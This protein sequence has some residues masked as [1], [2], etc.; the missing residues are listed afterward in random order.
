MSEPLTRE[1]IEGFDTR[2]FE[3]APCYLCGY[4]G[5]GYYQPETHPCAVRY[6]A[7]MEGKPCDVK[8]DR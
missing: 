7:Q 8:T 6:H 1:Q 2:K 4:N 5:E 3:H